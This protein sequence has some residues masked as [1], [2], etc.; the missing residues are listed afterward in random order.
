MEY[1]AAAAAT[2]GQ[3]DDYL[4]YAAYYTLST[5]R[6]LRASNRHRMRNL[7][8]RNSTRW[9]AGI[10]RKNALLDRPGLNEGS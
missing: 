5:Q 6:V 1:R 7:R 8:H 4:Q 2:A 3:T 9:V 10:W